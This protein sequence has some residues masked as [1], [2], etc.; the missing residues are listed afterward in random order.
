ML[1]RRD[2]LLCLAALLA[3][4]GG[5]GGVPDVPA[6][7]APADAG[8][9]CVEVYDP[10]FDYFPA[11]P[12]PRHAERFSVV[13]HRHYKVVTVTMP[14]ATARY[15]LVRC[16]TPVPEGVGGTVVEVPVR[17]IVTTSTTELPHL[18]SLSLLD[19][20]VGHDE[21]DYVSSP[22]VRRR[23]EDGRVAEV[24]ESFQLN[25][26][27]VL[28]L[29]P[30]LVLAASL[31]SSTNDAFARLGRA[32]IPVAHVPSFLETSPLGRAE[33]ILFTALFFNAEADAAALFDGVAE[34]YEELAALG[35]SHSDG[36]TVFASGP[37]GSTWYMPGGQSF[38]ARLV[39]DAGGR[40]LW[41]EDESPGSLALALENVFDRAL[42]ADVW[43]HPSRWRSLEEVAGVDRRFTSL[44]AYGEGRVYQNDARHNDAHQ[45]SEGEQPIG[46]NDYWEQGTARPDLVLADLLKIFHP[47]AVP[48]HELTF[49]RRLE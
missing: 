7:V 19:H 35:R 47:E 38:M 37:E 12:T 4:C 21:L 14:R 18:E 32:G 10:A 34:R 22:E 1:V 44:R 31:A 25:L 11:K 41:A 28:D 23:M 8:G 40:Y 13:Y 6:D 33:W 45:D 43:L 29:E 26:E 5:Q 2:L 42:E 48:G 3:A 49:H 20:L 39:A 46:A 9:R 27:V 24:G 15:V 30:D 17:G 36:P 16:G